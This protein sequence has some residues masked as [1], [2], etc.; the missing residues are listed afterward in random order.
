L[1]RLF[2]ICIRK[3]CPVDDLIETITAA[4]EIPLSKG[5]PSKLFVEVTT[6]CNLNC[7]M[8]VKQNS[9]G[10]IREGSMS[11]DIFEALSPAFPHLEALILNGIGESL[12]HPQLEAFIRSSKARMPENAWVGFQTNGMLLSASRAESLVDA[13]LDRI[14]LSMDTLSPESFRS[15]RNGGE[16]SSVESALSAMSRAGQ[17]RKG[18]RVGIEFVLMRENVRELPEVIRWAGRRGAAFVLVTQ[19]MPYDKSL[20]HQ[21]AYDTNTSDAISVYERWRRDALK[22]GVDIRRYFDIFM[23][24]SKTPEEQRICSLVERM[25][26]DAASR[27]IALHLER[28]I[29]RDEEWCSGVEEV[30]DEARHVAEVEGI[31]LTLPGTAPRNSRRCEFVESDGAFV[32]WDGDVHPCYFLW[33][34]YRCYVGGLE[35]HVRPWVF[36]NLKEKDIIA[37]WNDPVYRDF[38]QN[39]LRY[40]FPFC[41]DC[42][43]AL[44]DYVQPEEFEQD[45][46][47]SHV[48][49]AACLWC[50]GLFRCLQ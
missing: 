7:G 19:L 47:V 13:G 41:F 23:K 18:L 1:T 37:I 21:A 40:D 43:F 44:C 14:C 24:F 48:P 25:K 31:E 49:C 10:G 39:V 33:H 35:K 38:R 36:G 3:E 45:C 50:T 2:K 17:G 46:Y 8:C 26:N 42:G 34:R 20:L 27:G 29:G 5:H 6:R 28:L 32:S 9:Y 4:E 16:V 30:L 12:L 22:E 15:I 11:A